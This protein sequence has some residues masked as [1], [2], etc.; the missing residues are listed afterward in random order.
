M[1]PILRHVAERI[2]GCLFALGTPGLTKERRAHFCKRGFRDLRDAWW[3]TFTYESYATLWRYARLLEVVE[4]WNRQSANENVSADEKLLVVTLGHLGDVLQALPML[5]S[6]KAQKQAMQVELLV[7]PWMADFARSIP[8]VDNVIAY[9][10][11]FIQFHRGNRTHCLAYRE[12]QQFLKRLQEKRYDRLFTLGAGHLVELLI[13]HAACPQQWIGAKPPEAGYGELHN[14]N[15]VPYDTRSPEAA[16]LCG[17]LELAGMKAGPSELEYP[18]IEEEDRVFATTCLDR[19]GVERDHPVVCIAP[20]AG[21]SGKIWPADRYSVIG[22]W[23]MGEKK[24]KVMLVGSPEETRTGQQLQAG[25]VEQ[26]INLIGQTSLSQMA[27][28]V[29]RCD[30]LISNDCGPVHVAAALGVPTVTLFGPTR[31]EKWAP[32][33]RGHVYIRKVDACPDC[34]PWHPGS[35]CRHDGE[36]MKKISVSDVKEAVIQA[37]T[38]STDNNT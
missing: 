6:L 36:C 33:G 34:V 22:D 5:R 31:P 10:P 2:E 38:E 27:A 14:A 28:L 13:A 7:G 35:R 30:M 12:E 11:D 1:R 17:L 19:L 21:W 37:F 32:R 23:L 20:G 29:S 25:M 8:Y 9:S 15:L 16:R 3:P 4:N 26:P 24:A 18:R